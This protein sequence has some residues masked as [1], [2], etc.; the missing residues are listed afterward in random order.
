MYVGCPI[1]FVTSNAF[2]ATS[3]EIQRFES[4]AIT[5]GTTYYVKEI[6]SSTKFKISDT[7]NGPTVPL[8][9]EIGTML[10]YG[11]D[12]LGDMFRMRD[13]SGLRNMTL[14]GLLGTLGPINDYLTQ[15]PT[16]GSFVSLDPG[17]GPND[18]EA[19]IIRRSPYIQ[20]VTTFGIGCTGMKIDGTLHNGGNKS[21][22]CNDYTQILSDGIGIWCKGSGS[23]CEAVSVFS[24]YGYSGYF[25][26]DG[27]RIRATNGNSSYGQLGVVAEGYDTTETPIS[28]TVYNRQYE[29][30]ANIGFVDDVNSGILNY[31]FNNAGQ[32][33]FASTVNLLNYSNNFAGASWTND[34]NVTLTQGS[35]GPDSLTN[36]WIFTGLTSTTNSAFLSQSISIVPSTGFTLTNQPYVAS[37]Y[38]KQGTADYTDIHAVFSGSL[39]KSSGYVS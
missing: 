4:T 21:M 29:T 24:Y 39:T 1:V 9:G 15:R 30:Q 2:G 11:G 12:A 38:L 7:L 33:H 25:S 37:V 26:E 10:V 31:T 3:V 5:V 36:A 28:G 23:L 35:A 17:T 13:G 20:N 8:A 16:G 6:V 19:W 27:G 14:F 34:G 22:V 32:D 18:S